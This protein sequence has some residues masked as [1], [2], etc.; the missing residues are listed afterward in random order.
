M[1]WPRFSWKSTI[2]PGRSAARTRAAMAWK[3]PP[4]ESPESIDHMI[5][6]RPSRRAVAVTK[7]VSVPYGG[8]KRRIAWPAARW[9]VAS[10]AA[11]SWRS[12]PRLSAGSSR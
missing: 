9:A 10:P 12:A 6:T 11:I 3:L 2:E 1:V 7:A 8:R 5:S 4:I